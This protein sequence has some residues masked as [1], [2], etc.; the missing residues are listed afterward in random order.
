MIVLGRAVRLRRGRESARGLATSAPEAGR[1]QMEYQKRLDDE[2]RAL[3]GGDR[4]PRSP[5][6]P[7]TPR[8]RAHAHP[9]GRVALD[10]PPDDPGREEAVVQPLI[11]A[12]TAVAAACSRDWPTPSARGVPEEHP[13][14]RETSRGARRRARRGAGDEHH[15]L[16]VSRGAPPTGDRQGAADPARGAVANGSRQVSSRGDRSR[17]T[18]PRHVPRHRQAPSRFRHL[19]RDRFGALIGVGGFT[20]AYARGTSYLTND[21]KACLNCHVMREQYEGWTRQPSRGGGLQRLPHSARLRRQVRSPRRS[22]AGTT[23]SPSPPG[24]STSRSGSAAQPRHHRGTCQQ[25]PRAPDRRHRSRRRAEHLPGSSPASVPPERRAPQLRIPPCP[26]PLRS[27]RPLRVP[28]RRDR[29]RRRRRGGRRWSPRCWSTSSSSKQE[30]QN[31]FFRVVELTDDT[32]DPAVW[33][34]NFPLQYDEYKRTVDQVRTTL[35]R[36]RGGAAHPDAGRSALAS[37]R[38][39]SSK[40]IRGSTRMWAGYAFAKD[41]REERGH[42]YMLDDQT[43]TRAPGGREAARDLPA[44]PRLDLRR[45]Q[46]AGERR[47]DQGLREARTRCRYVEARKVVTHPVACIDCHDPKTHGSCAS[48]VPAFIEGIARSRPRRASRTTT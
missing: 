19:H 36:Q 25:L 43:F 15:R 17:Q 46:E 18:R 38:S 22:T 8:R 4:A 33:G 10:Q 34:K 13:P 12:S 14:A 20:F 1:R 35:R 31:P 16:R 37:S 39:A 42:A 11:C 26:R 7:R 28:P 2:D 40:R 48:P 45:L 47:P 9:E 41:F 3:S 24:S 32:D 23:P 6:P 27:R 30:A 44:L 21:P 29:R 5:P